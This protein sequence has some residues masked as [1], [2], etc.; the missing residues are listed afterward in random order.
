MG[1]MAFYRIGRTIECMWSSSI[2]S[3]CWPWEK[4]WNAEILKISEES[5][6]YSSMMLYCAHWKTNS[7]DMRMIP[8]L[9]C[10]WWQHA[11]QKYPGSDV[12]AGGITMKRNKSMDKQ[13]T[14]LLSTNMS[15]LDSQCIQL[16]SDEVLFLRNIQGL[17]AFSALNWLDPQQIGL[18]SKWG[19][20]KFDCLS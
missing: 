11:H 17:G 10:G 15:K 2:T 14:F 8:F 6:I 13:V 3:Y 5:C 20:S 12:K 18:V 19:T 4:R 9:V 16:L 7:L 1:A